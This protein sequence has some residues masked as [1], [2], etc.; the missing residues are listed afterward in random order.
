MTLFD[1]NIRRLEQEH[2][3]LSTRMRPRILGEFVGQQHLLGPGRI[4][5]KA[6]ESDQV[7]S[8]ILWG[9]PG[10]GK[11]TLA[12][13]ISSTTKANFISISAL[14]KLSFCLPLLPPI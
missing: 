11:T 6:I 3:P 8:M 14:A 7:P 4:L 1:H 5:R 2:A 10:S 12:H 9:P 13:L